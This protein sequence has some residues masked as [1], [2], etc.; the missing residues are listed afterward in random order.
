MRFYMQVHR[1]AEA[2]TSSRASL[3]CV[4]VATVYTDV[5]RKLPLA[6]SQLAAESLWS[7]LFGQSLHHDV[8][9]VTLDLCAHA[10]AHQM[11]L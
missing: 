10:A 4:D 5:G 9:V 8:I 1:L 11:P 6:G 3:L 2:T 7:C